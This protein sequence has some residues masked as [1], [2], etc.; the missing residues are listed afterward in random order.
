MN[1]LQIKA[2]I[3]ATIRAIA[4]TTTPTAALLTDLKKID[5]KETV[6]N[7]L[8][9][10]LSNADAHKSLI[11]CWL[12]TELI[13]KDKLNEALWDVIK[14]P[15]YNDHIKMI[16]FNMLKDLGNSID[17]DVISTYFE[18]FNELINKRDKS[19]KLHEWCRWN[20]K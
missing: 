15:E 12:L 3:L 11:I 20:R 4:G 18:Q 5:D 7:I 1:K 14:S 19:D 13:E 9:K 16:A 17:Y 6:F 8:L 2:E 10:E